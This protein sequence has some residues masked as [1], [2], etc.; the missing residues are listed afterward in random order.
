MSRSRRKFSG[1]YGTRATGL[2]CRWPSAA[3][4]D[5]KMRNDE[6]LNKLFSALRGI[7]MLVGSGSVLSAG[8]V[9]GSVVELNGG[10]MI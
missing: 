9:T 4:I 7:R 3:T 6:I 10:V 2:A 5:G 8:F 1:S